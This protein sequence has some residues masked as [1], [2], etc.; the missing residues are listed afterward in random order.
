MPGWARREAPPVGAELEF[1]LPDEQIARHPTERRADSRLMI[2]PRDG[3][4][5]AHRHF[6]ELPALLRPGDRLVVNDSRVMPAR[7]RARRASGGAVELLCLAPGPGP[8]PVLARPAR[9]LASGDLLT[10]DGGTAEVLEP[11]GEGQ[12]LV[13]FTPEPE[14]LMAA[15]GEMPLPPYLRRGIVPDDRVR[16]Q[17]VFAHALGS[18][19]A[20]TAGLHFDPPLLA[21]LD[22]AGI[23][24]STVTLHVGLGTF[25][26]LREEQ[27]RSGLLHEEP[28][29]VPPE[30]AEAIARTRATGG[31][32]IAVGTTSARTLESATPEGARA[33][34]PGRASTR[35]FVR[36]P[37]TFR[38]LDGLI[39]NFHLPGSSLL[40]LVA[41]LVDPPVLRRAYDDAIARGYRFY[42]YG[43]AMLVL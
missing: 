2:V 13:R 23:G 25:L 3:S 26:P 10:L 36:P 27:V 28:Y 7:L 38:A 40:L 19:A 5:P 29:E 16:Y 39:T 15:S 21:A 24:L 9:K 6:R 37:Y 18:A 14:V 31:R 1:D 8:I 35:L 22:Q 20:P 34:R 43:D 32:I 42:S 4:T 12:W 17:T 11:Q 33:P 30:S 41:A